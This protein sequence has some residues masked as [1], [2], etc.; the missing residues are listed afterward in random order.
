MRAMSMLSPIFVRNARY[1]MHACNSATL[2]DYGPPATVKAC[3]KRRIIMWATRDKENM[4]GSGMVTLRECGPEEQCLRP[5]A[6]NA[7]ADT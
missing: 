6:T 1:I 3:C 7:W 2:G 5:D 4:H